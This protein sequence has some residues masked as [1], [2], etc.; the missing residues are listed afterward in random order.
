MKI[1]IYSGAIPPPVFINNLING[2][3]N[4]N[5]TV[6]LYGKT[7]ERNYKFSSSAIV[8]RKVPITKLGII[9]YSIYALFKLIIMQP[10]L[11]LTIVKMLRQNST[12]WIQFLKR[13]CR[14]LPPFL[15]N[16]DIFHIQW[17]KT[18][19][20]YPEFIEKLT[21]PIVLSLRGTHI[22]VSPISDEGFS[23]SYKKYFPRING[24]HAVSQ[25]IAEEAEKYG[26]DIN[27]I[28]VINPAVDEKLL[29]YKADKVNNL[30]SEIL[31][32]ISVGR[33]HWIK[34]YTFVLDAMSILSKE[35]V[36]FNYTIIAGGRDQEN[37]L[38]QIHDLG[39]NECVSFINDE[40]S[41]DEVLKKVSECDLFLLPSLE[42]GISNA[43]IEAM[44][45]GLPVISTDCGGMG[46][47]IKNG[48]NGFLVPVRDA[49]SMAGTIRKF[50]DLDEMKKNNI[51]FNARETIKHNHL[52]FYQVD[53]FK[54]F[55]SKIV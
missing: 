41:H 21:C 31:H 48:E 25:A 4:K 2:L 23:L 34:G 28:T 22:N 38:Y 32:I 5:D 30:D 42:E 3:V 50:I 33:C 20:Q 1:G 35:K 14:V 53:Q 10:Q 8:K 37:I 6:I 18:L 54:S 9:L 13:S 19:V 12:N 15:D 39:L 52:L 49:D 24:F 40:L 17:A 55:Y 11:Y 51:I 26:A 7:S 43:V 36:D 27:K 46:E 16:L 47:I 45:L 29:N 44:A